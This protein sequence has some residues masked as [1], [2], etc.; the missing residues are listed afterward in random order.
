MN[1]IERTVTIKSISS[2]DQI[3]KLI[4]QQI[5]KSAHKKNKLSSSQEKERIALINAVQRGFKGRA[6][7]LSTQGRT[8]H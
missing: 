2:K 4:Q 7:S 3:T 1:K 6:S 5:T 8:Q